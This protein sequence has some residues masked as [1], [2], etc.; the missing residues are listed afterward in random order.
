MKKIL[1]SAAISKFDGHLYKFD[2]R[3]KHPVIDA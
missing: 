3:K 2:F 1:I